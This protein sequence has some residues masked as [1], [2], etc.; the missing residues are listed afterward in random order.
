MANLFELPRYIALEGPIRD[1][2]S[3]L[4][5]IIAEKLSG[6]LIVEPENNHFLDAFYE[7]ERGAAFQAKFEFL[8]QRYEQLRA[9]EAGPNSRKTT[10]ADY[11]FAK[12]QLVACIH[13]TDDELAVYNLYYNL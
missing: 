13:L 2:K 3:Y 6:Q 10:V 12:D 7:G 8:I 9:L 4:A 5:K 1:G 11:I